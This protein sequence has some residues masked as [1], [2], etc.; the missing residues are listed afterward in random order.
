L[1]GSQLTVRLPAKLEVSALLRLVGAAGGFA[2]VLAKGEP[3]AGAILVVIVEN[4]TNARAYERM[5]Q[6]DG[7]RVWHLGRRDD[8]Q[9]PR[10]MSDYLERRKLQDPDLW[11]VELDIPQGERF[12]GLTPPAH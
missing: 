4:G 11:I 5:P 10:L 2:T 8:S 6:A 9:E 3:D 7:S 1:P 12:I